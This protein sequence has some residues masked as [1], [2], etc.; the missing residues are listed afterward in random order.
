M[1]PTE[2]LNSKTIDGYLTAATHLITH[3][4]AIPLDKAPDPRRLHSFMG[5]LGIGVR[6]M[7]AAVAAADPAMEDLPLLAATF[8]NLYDA[9]YRYA[10]TLEKNHRISDGFPERIKRAR[11]TINVICDAD[12]INTEAISTALI[13]GADLIPD[14]PGHNPALDLADNEKTHGPAH[15]DRSNETVE[16]LAAALQQHMP[17]GVDPHTVARYV[18]S[19]HLDPFAA[20]V[21]V[22]RLST[23][24]ADGMSF[25]KTLRTLQRMKTTAQQSGGLAAEKDTANVVLRGLAEARRQPRVTQTQPT[26]TNTAP[27]WPQDIDAPVPYTMDSGI[28][29]LEMREHRKEFFT[30]L[31]ELTRLLGDRE[32]IKAA[33]TDTWTRTVTSARVAAFVDSVGE[34]LT[35]AGITAQQ[36]AGVHLRMADRKSDRGHEP[37][38]GFS[39]LGDE[40]LTA[41]TVLNT[42]TS[43]A[44]DLAAMSFD[45]MGEVKLDAA[46]DD[47]VT[48]A[49]WRAPLWGGHGPR[50]EIPFTETP[51]AYA[52]EALTTSFGW[53][54]EK[55]IDPYRLGRYFGQV[56]AARYRPLPT[57]STAPVEY[58][59]TT[60]S[61]ESIEP[62]EV[63]QELWRR[64]DLARDGVSIM[65]HAGR[66][67]P[68]AVSE[69]AQRINTIVDD[70]ETLSM[71]R[72]RYP[73]EYAEVVRDGWAAV[74]AHV[75]RAHTANHASS[76]WR[77]G[78]ER[79]VKTANNP[80]K[81]K[82]REKG[83]AAPIKTSHLPGFGE[84][85][86]PSETHRASERPAPPVRSEEELADDPALPSWLR[87]LPKALVQPTGTA[88]PRTRSR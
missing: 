25:E 52:S 64:R 42:L 51:L 72:R 63:T 8:V 40:I 66:L 50:P 27:R 76:R 85:P 15:S 49:Q 18:V 75:N 73:Q 79:A 16:P 41:H 44:D 58:I 24:T 83:D 65:L 46:L 37:G 22:R 17:P 82:P 26:A 60:E 39:R 88:T 30:N 86:A 45:V 77:L 3:A 14:L 48:A 35:Q 53:Y 69:G 10:T 56:A 78:Y 47:L 54:H 19:N 23:G 1:F 57:E 9:A 71:R 12:G 74:R 43:R 62:D 6:R 61:D 59:E 4:G 55:I 13:P 33:I 28:F 29:W 32:A 5:P 7:H 11:D 87:G 68:A 70:M 21:L 36:L 34:R 67:H 81:R 2:P 38:V 20:L 80:W 31:T 84:E